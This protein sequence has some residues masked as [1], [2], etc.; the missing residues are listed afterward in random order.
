MRIFVL[1]SLFVAAFGCGARPPRPSAPVA[2]PAVSS[3][4]I[5]AAAV[6]DIDATGNL[7][8]LITLVNRRSERIV[9]VGGGADDDWYWFYEADTGDGGVGGGHAS[10]DGRVPGEV[11]CPQPESDLIVAPGGSVGR[12][13]R[14]PFGAELKGRIASARM[15]VRI[16]LGSASLQCGPYEAVERDVEVT[17]IP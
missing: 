14:I 8:V 2:A 1:L 12:L 4:E 3:V 7:L 9:V 16:F 15:S 11:A 6:G 10:S 13:Q 17:Q 5:T